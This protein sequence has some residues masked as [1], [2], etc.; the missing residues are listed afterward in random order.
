M[1]GQHALVR[2]NLC[3]HIRT[4]RQSVIRERATAPLFVQ[5]LIRKPIV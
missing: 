2:T 3:T 1:V 4:Q 5:H